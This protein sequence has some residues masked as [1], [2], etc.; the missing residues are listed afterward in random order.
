MLKIRRSAPAP[1]PGPVCR[2][3][4]TAGESQQHLL[5]TVQESNP[6]SQNFVG[7]GEIIGKFSQRDTGGDAVDKVVPFDEFARDGQS[8]RPLR[9][10][11]LAGV[12]AAVEVFEFVGQRATMS[13]EQYAFVDHLG[14]PR[15]IRTAV[16][17]EG[18]QRGRTRP[19]DDHM[20][21]G[22]KLTPRT[23]LKHASNITPST[24]IACSRRAV[25]IEM[26]PNVMVTSRRRPSSGLARKFCEIEMVMGSAAG[27]EVGPAAQA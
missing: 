27:V 1:G 5:V 21:D 2:A 9:S 11:F 18:F 15:L 4:T 20:A 3:R 8:D 25:D 23:F 10:G 16:Q 7:D 14:R 19:F 12:F 26:M 13:G 6:V 24:D 22:R 17:H